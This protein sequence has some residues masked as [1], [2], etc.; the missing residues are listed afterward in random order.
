MKSEETTAGEKP[1]GRNGTSAQVNIP[2][3]IITPS[4]S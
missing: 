4:H 1:F 3:I 2:C